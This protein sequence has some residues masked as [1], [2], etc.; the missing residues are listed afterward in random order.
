MWEETWYL[1][2]FMFT[3]DYTYNK[4]SRNTNILRCNTRRSSKCPSTLKVDKNSK[5]H[6]VQDHNHKVQWKTKQFVMKQEMLQ[7]CR[8]TTLPLKEIFDNV[9]RK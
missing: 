5:V 3:Y 1:V 8:D 2:L 6:V 4:D 7:L 9:C